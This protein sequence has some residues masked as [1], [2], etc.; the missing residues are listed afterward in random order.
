LKTPSIVERKDI[1]DKKILSSTHLN[2]WELGDRLIVLY[3]DG[4]CENLF[5]YAK[6]EG[7]HNKVNGTMVTG[8]TRN[9]AIDKLK[10]MRDEG[11]IKGYIPGEES[12]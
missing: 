12:N 11:I 7:G 4:S 9:Q 1:M 6:Q 2:N 10:Q 8:K 3:E 5:V